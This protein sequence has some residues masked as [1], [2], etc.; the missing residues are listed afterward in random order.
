MVKSLIEP[1]KSLEEKKDPML[2]IIR[3]SLSPGSGW[4]ETSD[5]RE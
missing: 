3:G 5:L 4:V 1:S 2:E